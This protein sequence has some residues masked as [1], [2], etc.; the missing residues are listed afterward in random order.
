MIGIYSAFFPLFA[1]ALFGSSR[2]LITGPDAATCILVAATRGPLADG[3]PRRYASL[4]LGQTVMTGVLFV[5]AGVIKLGFFANF[6][7]QPILTGYLN[8]IALLI[9]VQQLSKL[10]GYESTEGIFYGK[11]LEFV[12][13]VGQSHWPT[14]VLGAAALVVLMLVIRFLPRLPA[15][16][17]VVGLSIVLVKSLG[18]DQQGVSVLGDV[19]G[20]L[21]S[22]VLPSFHAS[23]F[24]D[25]FGAAAGIMLVS[26]TNRL[27]TAKSFARRNGY[28]VNANQELIGFGACNLISGLT[29]GFPVTGADSRTAV[30]NA[31]GGMTQVTGMVAGRA[32]LLVLLFAHSPLAYVPTSELATVILVSAIGLFDLADLRLLCRM[33]YQEFLM[34]VATRWACCQVFCWRSHC[35]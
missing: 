4:L 23:V 33:S 21:P 20:S 35:R 17:V 12:E 29:L 10:F 15:A 6:L 9:I 19:P 34:L 25:L 1:Y 11:I 16:F 30:N 8:G 5:F 24:N 27:L 26:F 14:A 13:R 2:Q 28:E 31:M 18:L 3:D 22:I 32:M 7:S